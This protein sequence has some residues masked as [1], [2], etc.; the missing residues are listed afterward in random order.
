MIKLLRS[1]APLYGAVLSIA[2]TGGITVHVRGQ[3]MAPNEPFSVPEYSGVAMGAHL[4][5]HPADTK[6]AMIL[7]DLNPTIVPGPNPPAPPQI[8]CAS[9]VV[10][11]NPYERPIT[12]FLEARNPNGA[13]V[14]ST[15]LN[16]D[17]L[18]LREWTTTSLQQFGYGMVRMTTLDEEDATVGA[19]ATGAS[20]FMNPNAPNLVHRGDMR[21]WQQLQARQGNT[22]VHIGPFPFVRGTVRDEINGS[23]GLGFV[24]NPNST[25]NDVRIDVSIDGSYLAPRFATIAAYGSLLIDDVWQSQI[26]NYNSP[27]LNFGAIVTVTSVSQTPLPLIA[28]G[29]HFDCTDIQGGTSPSGGVPRLASFMGAIEP[30]SLLTGSE[31]TEW[32]NG[33]LVNSTLLVA[34]VSGSSTTVTIAYRDAQGSVIATISQP[35]GARQTT[36]VGR[37][38]TPTVPNVDLWRH[39]ATIRTSNGAKIIGWSMRAATSTENEARPIWGESLLGANGIEPGIGF[40][41]PTVV[42][43]PYKSVACWTPNRVAG[44]DPGYVTFLQETPFATSNWYLF[45]YY[46][47]DGNPNGF[48]AFSNLP[49]NYVSFTFEDPMMSSPQSMNHHCIL[50]RVAAP[51]MQDPMR[52]VSGLWTTGPEL[53]ALDL[54]YWEGSPGVYVFEPGPHK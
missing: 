13:V 12:V 24:M 17:P 52:A 35:L 42:V 28:E 9:H 3:E 15:F 36:F 33:M 5:G 20:R 26:A 21:S 23:Y 50:T 44:S 37:G 31:V 38:L 11:N 43:E 53:D 16:I 32:T 49:Q 29:Y 25:P 34:N 7:G 14:A 19:V 1:H 6:Y 46:R 45:R 39:T 41:D 47:Q 30:A 40:F 22:R 8:D 4:Q 48:G 2:A 27:V 10:I 51:F 54:P 18:G